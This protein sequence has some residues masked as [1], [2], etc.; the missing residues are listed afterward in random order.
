MKHYVK[1]NNETD[2]NKVLT[3]YEI[4][5]YMYIIYIWKQ[6]KETIKNVFRYASFTDHLLFKTRFPNSWLTY[7]AAPNTA[8][9]ISSKAWTPL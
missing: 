4:L 5:W 7:K 6:F 1:H 2:K 3:Y 9:K 8:R